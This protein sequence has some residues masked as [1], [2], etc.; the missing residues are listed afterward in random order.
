[1][2]SLTSDFWGPKLNPDKAMKA[3]V[4]QHVPKEAVKFCDKAMRVAIT[5]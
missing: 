5:P 2:S 3:T 1:M 4:I